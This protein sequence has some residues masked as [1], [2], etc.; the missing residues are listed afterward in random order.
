MRKYL[1]RERKMAKTNR[2]KTSEINQEN[3]PS[4]KK[5][6]EKL[7][8]EI[9]QESFNPDCNL[10]LLE[11]KIKDLERSAEDHLPLLMKKL[12]QGNS[13]EQKVVFDLLTR[14]KNKTVIRYLEE[15]IKKDFAAIKIMRQALLQLQKWEEKV[16][17][18]LL[19]HIEKGEEVIYAIEKSQEKGSEL[20]ETILSSLIQKFNSLPANI[21]RAITKQV[22]QEYPSALPWILKIIQQGTEL[23]SEMIN[24]LATKAPSL[25]VGELLINWLE[26]TEDKDIRRIIKRYLFQMKNRGLN[27]VI[28]QTE[29]IEPVKLSFSDTLPAN[30]YITGIDYLGERLLFISKSVLRWGTIFLQITLSDQEGIKNFSA[31]DLSRK[32]AKNFLKN[33]RKKLM[34]PVVEIPSDYSYFL[35]DEAYQINLKKGIPLPEQFIHFKLEIDELKGSITQPI[36]YS[37]FSPDFFDENNLSH[38]RKNYHSLFA[39]EDFKGWFLEPRLL[40]DF[41][42]KINEVETSPLILS[43]Y[44]V[45]QRYQTIFTEAARKIFDQEW[46]KIYQRRL[47][48][49]AYILFCLQKE[50]L[51]KLTLAA[52]YDLREEGVISENHNFIRELVKRSLLFYK[53]ANENSVDDSLIITP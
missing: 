42:E 47:E 31:F 50:E 1:I 26:K 27:I 3:G 34:I 30:A 45:E 39:E 20:E 38:L 43:P 2:K 36:I 15:I 46:R 6:T 23:D 7:L 9:I 13:G 24:L 35:I 11:N 49:T 37:C 22:I 41:L 16:D 40:T 32:E 10:I 18:N 8:E 17:E 51:A 21:K 12:R 33:I 5:E 25:E 48:E 19:E 14:R 4:N 28:P 29:D 52:G 44:Q 53:E